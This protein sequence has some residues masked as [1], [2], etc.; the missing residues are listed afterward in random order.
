MDECVVSAIQ[1]IERENEP[2]SID[3]VVES[4]VPVVVQDR[5]INIMVAVNEERYVKQ[6]L[7][8]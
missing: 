2:G 1:E 4:L 6:I 5:H 3:E 8:M 7:F